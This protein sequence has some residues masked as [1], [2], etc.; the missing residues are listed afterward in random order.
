M[1]DLLRWP[2]ADAWVPN[3]HPQEALPTL[4]WCASSAAG[5]IARW[6]RLAFGNAHDYIT[7]SFSVAQLDTQPLGPNG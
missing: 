1:D 2:E 7:T 4:T 5:L 3:R 6:P